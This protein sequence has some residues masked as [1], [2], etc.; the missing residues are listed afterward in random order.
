VNGTTSFSR[1]QYN[2][3]NDT[4]DIR[5]SD[6][7]NNYSS[8]AYAPSNQPN[9]TGAACFGN[10]DTANGYSSSLQAIDWLAYQGRYVNWWTTAKYSQFNYAV[11]TWTNSRAAMTFACYANP[12]GVTAINAM[13]NG[14]AFPSPSGSSDGQGVTAI[15]L[16]N[17]GA[18][19]NG[20]QSNVL[21]N[22]ELPVAATGAA[23]LVG[24]QIIQGAACA[25]QY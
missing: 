14:M 17:G 9:A 15:Y 23:M 2:S 19:K 1:I 18:T 22:Q 8:T 10:C 20:G 7:W 12:D 4:F 5:S 3:N 16:P 24:G 11:N 25:N 21:Q 13:R 6:S